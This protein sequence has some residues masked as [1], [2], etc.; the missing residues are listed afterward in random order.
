M[1]PPQAPREVTV[2][3]R[4]RQS[5]GDERVLWEVKEPLVKDYWECEVLNEPHIIH[6]ETYDSELAGLREAFRGK[7]VLAALRL[8]DLF[9]GYDPA[10]YEPRTTEVP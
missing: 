3:L 4:F 5:N 7:A 9:G 10:N 6:G 2:G 1:S 8:D